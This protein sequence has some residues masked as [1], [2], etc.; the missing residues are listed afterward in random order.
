MGDLIMILEDVV[1]IGDVDYDIG[2]GFI[3]IYLL[4]PTKNSGL[5][6]MKTVLE[7]QQPIDN[8]RL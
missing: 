2:T 5:G 4:L 1:N 8:N 6:H 3:F 7:P